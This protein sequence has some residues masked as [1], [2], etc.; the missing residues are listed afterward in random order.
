MHN[1]EKKESTISAIA[2]GAI[3]GFSASMFPREGAATTLDSPS[4]RQKPHPEG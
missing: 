3:L 1:P 4:R 2:E